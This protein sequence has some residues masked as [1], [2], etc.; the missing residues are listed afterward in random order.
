MQINP[1]YTKQEST[2]DGVVLQTQWG[3]CRQ[4]NAVRIGYC[5]NFLAALMGLVLILKGSPIGVVMDVLVGV[6]FGAAY[7]SEQL[8][9]GFKRGLLVGASIACVVCAYIAALAVVVGG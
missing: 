1:L 4:Q 8:P 5:V 7:F 6:S 9:G 2:E 3:Y